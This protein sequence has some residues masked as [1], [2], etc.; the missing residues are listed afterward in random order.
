MCGEIQY[1][2]LVYCFRESFYN[3]NDIQDYE[4][5]LAAMQAQGMGHPNSGG[6]PQYGHQQMPSGYYPN[7]Q[8][9]IP[10]QGYG[11]H[12]VGGPQQQV[13]Q[14]VSQNAQTGSAGQSHQPPVDNFRMQNYQYPS[15][16]VG[17]GLNLSSSTLYSNQPGKSSDPNSVH[18]PNITGGHHK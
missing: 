3:E 1:L 12:P 8:H 10:N 4:R 11:Q 6:Y 13:G 7:V 9:G 14:N 2:F 15:Q 5:Q 17:Y 18:S 16:N